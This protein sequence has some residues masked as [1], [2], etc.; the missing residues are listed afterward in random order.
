VRAGAALVSDAYEHELQ[1]LNLGPD[2]SEAGDVWFPYVM[3][4]IELTYPTKS[5]LRAERIDWHDL[6]EDLVQLAA[7]KTLVAISTPPIFLHELVQ[8]MNN[9][10]RRIDFGDRLTIITAGGWKRHAGASVSR[11][12]LENSA[13]K[14][15]QLAG[16]HQIR[17]AFNQVEL[18]TVLFEC[19]AKRKHVPPWVAAFAR[20]PYNLQAL[21]HGSEGL[22][23]FLDASAESY[24]AFIVGDDL[25]TV[26]NAQC[27]CGRPG[28]TITFKRRV[29]HRDVRGCALSI[30]QQY[31]KG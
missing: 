29:E 17:D 22:L 21:P 18:N 25:G 30:N 14:V 26:D 6:V 5:Y 23:S 10:M 24:P 12:E 28:H 16:T 8:F 7:R 20:S 15:F 2:K 13:A 3:S 9:A 11:P 19:E 27:A 1:M 31:R 4:L